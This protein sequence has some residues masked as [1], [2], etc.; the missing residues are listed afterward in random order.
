MCI[1]DSAIDRESRA[2][3]EGAT[4]A[5]HP[6]TTL[7]DERGVAEVNIPKGK[8][9]LFVSGKNYFPFRSDGVA[10]TEAVIEAELVLDSGLT[11]EDLWS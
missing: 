10:K 5:V 6:Y 4:V 9:R 7:T 1:R 2:P 3:V 8:Y 11:D